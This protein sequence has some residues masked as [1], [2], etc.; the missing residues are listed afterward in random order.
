MLSVVCT[1]TA[2]AHAA[3]MPPQAHLTPLYNRQVSGSPKIFVNSITCTT[4]PQPVSLRK[5]IAHT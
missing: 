3:S 4:M 1:W 5:K 2:T